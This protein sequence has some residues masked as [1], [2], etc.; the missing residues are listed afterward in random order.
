MGYTAAFKALSDMT[1]LRVLYVLLK[2]KREVCICE[3]MDSLEIKPY[4]A[5][6]C[7]RE[8]K[9]AGFVREK[10]EGRFVFYKTND[11][12]DNFL[13]KLF[14]LIASLPEKEFKEDISRMNKRLHL[15]KNGKVVVT[16]RRKK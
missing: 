5:S 9:I 14:R 10:K 7:L 3:L 8:L 13:H 6:R 2:A 4:H 16:M 15:R 11:L 1:R 12:K